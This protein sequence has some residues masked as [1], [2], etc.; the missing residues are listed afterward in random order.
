[1]ESPSFLEMNQLIAELISHQTASQRFSGQGKVD[2]TMFNT[3]LVPYPRIHF[4]MPSYAQFV[5]HDKKFEGAP[6]T[7]QLTQACFDESNF[8]LSPYKERYNAF[9]NIAKANYYGCNITYRGPVGQ[10][11]AL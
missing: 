4:M 9:T 6:S 10:G 8:L 7:D 5:P 2:F 11:E 1:M 3:N